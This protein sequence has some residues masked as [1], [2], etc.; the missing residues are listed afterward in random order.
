VIVQDLP[1]AS[2]S[3]PDAELD[4]VLDR[5]RGLAGSSR[6]VEEL[7]GGL[8]NRNV[9]VTTPDLRVVVRRSSEK[10]ELLAIDREAE[11]RNGIAASHAGVGPRVVEYLPGEGV[12]AVEWIDGRTF[13]DAD[14]DD[15]VNL[16][17]VAALCARLH[18]GPRFVTDFDMFA[19]QRGYLDIV[20]DRGFWL[21][22]DYVDLMPLADRIRAA[23][24]VRREGTVPCHN[25]LLAANIIDAGSRLWFID[26]E[27]AGNNDACF[28]LGNIASEAHLGPDRLAE[29]VTAYYGYESR[30]K[31]ARAR[32]FGVMSN[33]GWTLWASI[34]DAVSTVDFDFW[35]W[36][37]EK[38]ERAVAALRGPELA[39][40]ITDVQ[41][42]D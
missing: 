39:T 14:L 18:A 24:A 19:I 32:L 4:A 22:A 33:F 21:P 31:I 2:A 10:S 37:L 6:Q 41:Q 20:T 1:R 17:R 3:A 25:D 7:S 11:Y 5:I 34:Q 29:L 35:A 15:S 8:T 38:Y 9:K 42:A 12:L 13:G 23:M 36:G 30:A 40:L 28:E 27:Y 26:Y 16:A